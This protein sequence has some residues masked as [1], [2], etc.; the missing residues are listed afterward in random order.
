MSGFANSIGTEI[1]TLGVRSFG[2]GKEAVYATKNP[3]FQRVQFEL[4][5]GEH[6]GRVIQVCLKAT[7]A[8]ILSRAFKAYNY[9]GEK[10]LSLLIE[11]TD[12]AIRAWTGKLQ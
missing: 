9:N 6:R 5:T 3:D 7:K 4:L 2:I 8:D 10:G 12:R 11:S 1:G